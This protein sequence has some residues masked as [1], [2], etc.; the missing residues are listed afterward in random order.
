MVF[1]VFIFTDMFQV[2]TITTYIIPLHTGGALFLRVPSKEDHRGLY[3]LDDGIT[4]PPFTG[5]LFRGQIVLTPGIKTHVFL[6]YTKNH[7]N[8]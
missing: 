4:I 6:V 1:T 5:G 2:C 3:L 7:F 8:G